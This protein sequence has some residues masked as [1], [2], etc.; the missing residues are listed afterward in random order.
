MFCS[1]TCAAH[2]RA[3]L[4]ALECKFW[5][6]LLGSNEIGSVEVMA[7]RTVLMKSPK[8][9]SEFSK[10]PPGNVD[11]EADEFPSFFGQRYLPDDY[12]NVFCL[13]KNSKKHM[14][15]FVMQS[16]FHAS[17][18]MKLLDEHY[19][20]SPEGGSMCLEKRLRDY[21]GGIVLRHVMN[22]TTCD[23]YA[24]EFVVPSG[25]NDNALMA[26]TSHVI[27]P[28]VIPTLILNCEYVMNVFQFF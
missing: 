9:W 16:A 5:K 28:T 6:T 12:A 27:H 3:K 23:F 14:L 18:V 2:P 10:K 4:H 21:V 1:A 17:Y 22:Y 19:F 7:M 13:L 8:E 11:G 20:S 24:R 15:Q 25:Y 26:R